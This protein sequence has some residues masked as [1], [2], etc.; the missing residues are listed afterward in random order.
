MLSQSGQKDRSLFGLEINREKTRVVEVK[1]EGGS[2]DFPGYTLRYDR[3]LKGRPRKY[4][5]ATSQSHVPLPQLVER[6]AGL[7]GRSTG[8]CGAA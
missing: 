5:T 8:S 4:L 7:G 1:P 3:N 2:L 6:W